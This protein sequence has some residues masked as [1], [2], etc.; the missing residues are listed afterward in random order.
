MMRLLLL[1]IGDPGQ[2]LEESVLGLDVDQLDC[3]MRPEGRLHLLCLTG[4]KQTV[5][6]EDACQL[7]ADR[8]MHQR[9]RHRRVDTAGEPADHLGRSHLGADR[10]DLGLDD[11]MRGPGRR[12]LADLVEESLEDLIASLGV[13]HL[14]VKLNSIQAVFGILHGRHGGARGGGDH[15]EALR[16]RYHLILV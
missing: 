1:G 2:G 12:C 4:S 6:D 3:E 7:V 10:G 13:S 15:P 9:R 11:R 5:V 16:R 14:R 8:R